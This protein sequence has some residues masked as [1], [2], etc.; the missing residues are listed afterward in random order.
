MSPD[1]LALCARAPLLM[2][3]SG[4]DLALLLDGARVV[5][6]PDAAPLFTQGDPA[7]RFFIV[8]A[9]RATL[10]ILTETGEKSVIE[11]FDPICSFAEAAILSSGL[12]PLHCEVATGSR[13]VHIPAALFLRRLEER[14]ALGLTLLSGLARWRWRLADEIAG[15]KSR[16]PAQRLAAFLLGLA[17][18][19]EAEGR[20]RLP[21]S[22][23]V[24]ASRIGIAPESLSR[25]LVRLRSHGV[26][27]RGREIILADIA[28]LRRFSSGEG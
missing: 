13:L 5:S 2:G 11:L 8:L 24:L 7:D 4:E 19:G 14:P 1:D 12:F 17:P 3:L 26:E 28:A 23:T 21:L 9:G 20:V 6:Y 25:A 15:L 10:F 16:S 27:A 22:K 18:A